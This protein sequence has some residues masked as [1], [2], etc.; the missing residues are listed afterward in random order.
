MFGNLQYYAFRWEQED[1]I[2]YTLGADFQWESNN[3]ETISDY[4]CP[5]N[6]LMG[7]LL[8]NRKKEWSKNIVQQ[9][10]GGT[11]ERSN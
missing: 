7:L 11:D 8:E 3:I 6:A 5:E 10:Y 1:I 4:T 2:R 9:V